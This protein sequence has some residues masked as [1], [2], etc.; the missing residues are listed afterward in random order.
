ML[1]VTAPILDKDQFNQI[2]N[3][4]NMAVARLDGTP[5]T[6]AP[7]YIPITRPLLRQTHRSSNFIIKI[8]DLGSGK[9]L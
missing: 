5:E 7:R 3:S 1:F 6:W 4:G 8:S 9:V 2:D